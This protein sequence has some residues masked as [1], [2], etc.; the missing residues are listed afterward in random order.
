MRLFVITFCLLLSSCK[1]YDHYDVDLEFRDALTKAPVPEARVDFDYNYGFLLN[2]PAE[3]YI[4]LDSGAARFWGIEDGLWN[5][6]IDASG[7]DLQYSYLKVDERPEIGKWVRCVMKR[8]FP[9]HKGRFIEFRV[10]K[11]EEK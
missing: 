1:I 4:D 2:P 7:Y 5:L 6:K 10:I 11:Q 3:G 9:L 8:Q